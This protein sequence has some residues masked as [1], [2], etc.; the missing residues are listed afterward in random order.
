[1][2][3]VSHHRGSQ[4]RSHPARGLPGVRVQRPGRSDGCASAPEDC[5]GARSA[6]KEIY[7]ERLASLNLLNSAARRGIA[8][9]KRSMLAD[10]AN[11]Q[12][13]SLRASRLEAR[14]LSLGKRLGL[15]R[16]R[17]PYSDFSSSLMHPCYPQ[18]PDCS[19]RIDP[20]GCLFLHLLSAQ[21]SKTLQPASPRHEVVHL[22]QPRRKLDE[23]GQSEKRQE[24]MYK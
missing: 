4:Q 7:W 8:V 11:L 21:L 3:T 1:M 24:K 9:G 12:S 14:G 5:G 22:F 23:P 17:P 10:A 18:L 13:Q 20:Y 19:S 16:R 6:S 15:P 2:T